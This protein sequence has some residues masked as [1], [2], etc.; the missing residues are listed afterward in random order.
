MQRRWTA[1]AAAITALDANGSVVTRNSDPFDGYVLTPANNAANPTN[2]NQFTQMEGN[3]SLFW[4]LAVNL[5]V[6]ILVPDNTPFDQ[7]LEANAGAFE[8]LGEPGE[9]G[10][11]NDQLTCGLAGA[12]PNYCFTEL[13]N[14]KRDSNAM[15]TQGVTGEGGVGGHL[16]SSPGTR[17]PGSNEPDPL[18]GLDLFFA[19]NL[20]LKNPNFRTGRCG[21]CHAVP[22]L[23]DHTMPFTFKAQLRDRAVT[24]ANRQFLTNSMLRIREKIR[25]ARPGPLP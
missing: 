22:T 17:T 21:E 11:V 2:S 5:W 1:A 3:F 6:G 18:L 15:A 19:S 13:G 16:V 14:F 20:S 24:A 9:R 8:T 4:G 12:D 10:L 23:T 7:V 25:Y